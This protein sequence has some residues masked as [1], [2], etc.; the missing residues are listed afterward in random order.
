MKTRQPNLIA[1]SIFSDKRLV[2]EGS[3]ARFFHIC[4]S[5]T[6]WVKSCLPGLLAWSIFMDMSLDEW[7]L[8][9]SVFL[10][11]SS[12]WWFTTLFFFSWTF[13]KASIFS[14]SPWNLDKTQNTTN[15]IQK[16]TKTQQKTQNKIYEVWNAKTTIYQQRKLWYKYELLVCLLFTIN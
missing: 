16:P 12:P 4:V 7:R 2:S 1:W 6:R 13:S 3:S 14:I 8:V 10:S 15:K 5:E 9:C 11:A